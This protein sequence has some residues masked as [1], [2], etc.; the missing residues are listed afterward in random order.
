MW[1]QCMVNIFFKKTFFD[2]QRLWTKSLSLKIVNIII[3]YIQ[4]IF[5]QKLKSNIVIGSIISNYQKFGNYQ[6]YDLPVFWNVDD[7]SSYY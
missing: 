6:R 4:H 2:F 7:F 3:K 1:S 5:T